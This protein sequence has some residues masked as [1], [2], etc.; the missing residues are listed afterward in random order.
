M[1]VSMFKYCERPLTLHGP[2]GTKVWFLY[3]KSCAKCNVRVP[4]GK[5]VSEMCCQEFAN[6]K[7]MCNLVTCYRSGMFELCRTPLNI[8]LCSRCAARGLVYCAVSFV[9][10]FYSQVTKQKCFADGDNST[11]PVILLWHVF[12]NCGLSLP[13]L[14]FLMCSWNVIY[15]NR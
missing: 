12:K 7:G 15:V 14:Y 3:I 9:G 8:S 10:R 13:N 2:E 6:H 11:E 4:L 5:I 1:F